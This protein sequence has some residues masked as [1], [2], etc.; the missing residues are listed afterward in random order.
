MRSMASNHRAFRLYFRRT[1]AV[2]LS[3]IISI[4]SLPSPGTSLWGNRE[5]QTSRLL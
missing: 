4:A 5:T 1:E 3:L 2:S